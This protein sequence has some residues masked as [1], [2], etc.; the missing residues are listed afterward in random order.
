MCEDLKRYN[1]QVYFV[2]VQVS[3]CSC[4]VVPCTLQQGVCTCVCMASCLCMMYCM[5][6][7]ACSVY[8]VP[9]AVQY[10]HSDS[11]VHCLN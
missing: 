7:Y 3:A 6:N 9:S 4:T 5:L 10:V 2:H 1:I 11:R 8:V